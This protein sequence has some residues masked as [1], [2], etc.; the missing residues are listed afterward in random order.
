MSSPSS[1]ID[2]A[3]KTFISP[4]LNF[5]TNAFCSFCLS[6]V[7]LPSPWSFIACPTK[8]VALIFGSLFS[9][10]EIVLTVSRNW[11]KIIIFEFG[12]FW[13]CFSTTLLKT[14]I[15]GCSLFSVVA[16]M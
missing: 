9:S 10:S 11:A 4:A 6:P 1:A 5:S 13:N 14:F 12:S 7:I 3:T 8:F 15:F 16:S 2:V